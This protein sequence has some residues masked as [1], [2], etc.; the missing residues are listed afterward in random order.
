MFVTVAQC[1]ERALEARAETR[2]Q[3]RDMWHYQKGRFL[4]VLIWAFV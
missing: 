4:C 1:E 2:D 3:R